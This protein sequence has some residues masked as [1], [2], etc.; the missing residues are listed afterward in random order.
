MFTYLSIDLFL[1]KYLE[2]IV[3]YFSLILGQS[4]N[5]STKCTLDPIQI[6]NE[7][8]ISVV[9]FQYFIKCY[10]DRETCSI[11]GD[12]NFLANCVTA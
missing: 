8:L 9:R 6:F 1:T 3:H 7:T 11:R 2:N 4:I 12:C 10:R 5:Y